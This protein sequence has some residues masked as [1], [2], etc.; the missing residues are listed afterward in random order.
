[1][2]SGVLEYSSHY[3]FENISGN[4]AIGAAIY[5]AAEG[6][7]IIPDPQNDAIAPEGDVRSDATSGAVDASKKSD[8]SASAASSVA[9]TANND[10]VLETDTNADDATS[11][12]MQWC[13]NNMRANGTK[14]DIYKASNATLYVS[15][16]S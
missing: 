8:D 14:A 12:W 4:Q 7:S 1:V 15:T 6:A 5:V 13:Y 16:H 11:D 9:K 10:E 2:A 3:V